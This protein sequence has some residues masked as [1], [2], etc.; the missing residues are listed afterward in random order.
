MKVTRRAFLSSGVGAAIAIIPAYHLATATDS[1]TVRVCLVTGDRPHRVDVAQVFEELGLTVDLVA[2][3]G[4]G[5]LDPASSSLLWI[6]S[7]T[8][9]D[10]MEISA[11][12]LSM[13][14]K[15]LEA[16]NGVFVEFTSNFPDARPAGPIRRADVA[17]L[18][19]TEA[20]SNPY[21]LPVGAILD[22]HDAV[23][24]PFRETPAASAI[25]QIAK[26]AGVEKMDAKIPPKD[27]IPGVLLGERGPGHFAVAA[28]SIS[29]FTRRQY[30]PQ[31]HWSRLIRDLTLTLLPGGARSRVLANYIPLQ[32]HTEPRR[33]VPPGTPVCLVVET[34]SGATLSL[35]GQPNSA[36]KETAPGRY[37][38]QLPAPVPSEKRFNLHAIR[39]QAART[40]TAELR[41]EDRKAAYR[42]ALDNNL[43]WFEE[44][45]V[46]LRAD[47]SLGV[48]EWISGPD[49]E[50]NRIPFG[51]R[52]G[53]SPERADCVFESALAYWLYGKVAA[54]DQ[55]K[56]VG[57][58]MLFNV[59]D[60]QRLSVNDSFY[61]LWYTRGREGPVFQDDEAWAVM[62][63]LAGYR[64]TQQPM[65]LHRGRL[66]ADSAA[67]VF[68]KGAPREAEA[69]DPAHPRPSDRGQMIAAWLYAYGVTGDRAFLTLALPAL[70][71]LM[72]S[73][74]KIAGGMP[75]HTGE[76][77]RFMLPLAFASVYSTDPSFPAALREQADYLVSRM[78][79]CGAIQE[80]GVYTGSKVQGGDLSLIH[81]SSEP[82]SDQL[83]T[84]S[85]A[86]MNF[87]IAYKATGDQFYRENFFR[88]V[89]FLV[90]IQIDSRD[91]TINGGWMRGFDYALWE[92][93]G[94]NADQSWTAYCLETGWDNAI[95]DMAIELYLLDDSFFEG[96]TP[97][98]AGAEA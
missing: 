2:E 35:A 52:Q 16:G 92:Y 28:T 67:K 68:A 47:G 64:Y 83:Y 89:D 72:D 5:K 77:T 33:W 90:R 82:I 42:R 18:F 87:W 65:F 51:K 58:N 76:S 93:Y 54:S 60:F 21:A 8:Y 41:V 62:G 71:D 7:A 14:E 46:L 24:L 40:A 97:V 86:A 11:A 95:I 10:P 57:R 70:R 20:D 13:I 59:M 84:T 23:C 73:F 55:H 45:G 6:V 36:W 15:F 1:S 44:S 34:T 91:R 81:D 88:V 30:A 9:P 43:R 66:V 61:G 94:S 74:P 79:P 38:T 98:S 26:I 31:E 22:P 32:L 19:V 80:E 3:S 53:Y 27:L 17:R 96:R 63:S 12:N 69:S 78:A 25:V 48:A 4:V 49:I 56:A 29:E 85:F 39:G 75:A 37:E 50:G